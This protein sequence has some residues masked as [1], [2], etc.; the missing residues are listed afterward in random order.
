[1][2]ERI[3]SKEIP[4]ARSAGRNAGSILQVVISF[5]A[6]LKGDYAANAFLIAPIIRNGF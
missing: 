6:R 4:R 2:E 5:S 1:M 3:D